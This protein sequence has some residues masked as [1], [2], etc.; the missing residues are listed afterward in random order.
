VKSADGDLGRDVDSPDQGAR[1]E[2]RFDLTR[3]G[4]AQ[5]EMKAIDG[6]FEATLNS[7]GVTR[8][9]GP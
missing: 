7:G 3:A 4:P 2:V 1:G 9:S 6:K 8:P 5:F